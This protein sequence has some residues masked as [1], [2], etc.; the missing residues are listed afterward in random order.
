[1]PL[2]LDNTRPEAVTAAPK[3]NAVFV[4]G[5][6][7]QVNIHVTAFDEGSIDRVE[8]WINDE[9]VKT[10]S[11][12]PFNERWK[13]AMQDVPSAQLNYPPVQGV[14][15]VTDE[16][17]G[18]ILG[19]VQVILEETVDW[20]PDFD[21]DDSRIKRGRMR[22]FDSGFGAIYTA[23]GFY[24]ERVALQIKVYDRAGNKTETETQYFYVHHAE[25][26]P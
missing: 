11:V 15:Q 2:V 22:R 24:L 26:N 21:S 25:P 7:E 1:M 18:R 17:T 14:K 23:D 12:A 8:F 5:E 20:L 6:D 10:S 3:P 19:E 13:I 9:L 16:E 4:E